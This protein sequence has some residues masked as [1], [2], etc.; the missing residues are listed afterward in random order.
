ML[1]LETWKR[2]IKFLKEF[3]FQEK[4]LGKTPGKG[5]PGCVT[6][7]EHD[8]EREQTIK[9]DSVE[10]IVIDIVHRGYPKHKREIIF[11]NLC[12]AHNMSKST[13]DDGVIY[14]Q[15]QRDDEFHIV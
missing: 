12:K 9:N 4:F 11:R 10:A 1:F 5:I 14:V 3:F 8:F 15:S 6:Q 7:G 13:M 2:E